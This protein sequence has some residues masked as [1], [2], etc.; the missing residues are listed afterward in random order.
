VAVPSL[1]LPRR[2]LSEA[3]VTCFPTNRTVPPLLNATLRA[4][5]D[6]LFFPK[7]RVFSLPA[8][9]LGEHR[10]TPSLFAH[11]VRGRE[12]PNALSKDKKDTHTRN[13]HASARLDQ[14]PPF[15]SIPCC[16][17]QQS[18][19]MVKAAFRCKTPAC[20]GKLPQGSA[21]SACASNA[22]PTVWEGSNQTSKRVEYKTA[23]SKAAPGW[24]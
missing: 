21:Q 14:N 15:P 8:N 4:A 16:A 22:R 19:I 20:A 24:L 9:P 18:W 17:W 23:N 2:T 10:L 13:N 12:S 5:R 7:F 11:T 6:S 3:F 1:S